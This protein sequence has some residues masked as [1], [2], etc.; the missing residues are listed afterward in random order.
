LPLN[1]QIGEAL[2][3]GTQ[4]VKDEDGAS[5]PMALSLSTVEVGAPNVPAIQQVFGDLHLEKG[6]GTVD[7]PKLGLR[8]RGPGTQHY[9]LRATNNHDPAGG[10]AFIIRNEDQNRDDFILDAQGNASIAGDLRLEKG[11]GEIDG[12]KLGI[13]SRGPGTQHYSLRATNNRDPAGGRR[14]VIRNEDVGRDEVV[15][16][17]GG[18]VTFAGDVRLTGADCAESFRVEAGS[19]VEPG[20]VLVMSEGGQLRQCSE[21]YDR[22]VVGVV[23]GAGDLRPGIVLGTDQTADDRLP[24]A[25]TGKVFC[26]VDAGYGSIAVGDMLTTSPSTGHA[27]RAET[28]LKSFG[29]VVGKALRPLTE[30]R[31]LIPI[32]IALQ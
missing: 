13:R 28:S 21:A 26:K 10:R 27:M 23:S 3:A 5:S 2:N 4:P 8:S 11:S 15:L 30:G 32:L 29:S 20:T 18:N 9:V 7:G 16:D 24:V 1:L 14:L 12:P 6:S 19:S 25:L 22:S 17:P 31:G